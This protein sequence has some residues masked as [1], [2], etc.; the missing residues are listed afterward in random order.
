[1]SE[2]WPG[3]CAA[4]TARGAVRALGRGEHVQAAAPDLLAVHA[5]V[6]LV[7]HL[8]L[9]RDLHLLPLLRAP[10]IQPSQLLLA[11][12]LNMTLKS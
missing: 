8:P 4:R 5:R 11:M 1:M 6:H 3:P 12:V 10:A 2:V 9:P 7:L